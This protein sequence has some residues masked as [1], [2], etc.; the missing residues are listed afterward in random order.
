MPCQQLDGASG[1]YVVRYNPFVYHT[2]LGGMTPGSACESNVVPISNVTNDCPYSQTPPA[3]AKCVSDDSPL[4]KAGGLNR[5]HS[6]FVLPNQVS[7]VH[8]WH[9]TEPSAGHPSVLSLMEGSRSTRSGPS[10]GPTT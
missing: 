4:V 10:R 7:G 3:R 6:L 8:S 2:D 5:F 1:F 9:V